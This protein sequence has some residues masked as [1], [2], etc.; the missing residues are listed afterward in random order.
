M[1]A[2]VAI[3]VAL[4]VLL[5]TPL[6]AAADDD[7]VKPTVDADVD[8]VSFGATLNE[9]HVFPYVAVRGKINSGYYYVC[10]MRSA[11]DIDQ[12]SSDTPRQDFYA[13]E[14]R[15]HN[16]KPNASYYEVTPENKQTS[17]YIPAAGTLKGT[18]RIEWSL[19]RHDYYFKGY[20]DAGGDMWLTKCLATKHKPA[21]YSWSATRKYPEGPHEG[22]ESVSD[23]DCT[24]WTDPPTDEVRTE[25]P[26][27]PT[28]ETE[29]VSG[30]TGGRGSEPDEGPL[31]QS[32]GVGAFI[33][34]TVAVVGLLLARRR[35]P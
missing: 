13:Y 3:L 23:L 34:L 19:E 7:P 5:L 2:Q 31:G 29:P 27:T 22:C 12:G 24:I 9:T 10:Q 8:I 26:P 1:Q 33:V 17:R 16:S 6:P 20:R 35:F 32:P 28:D 25:A 4:S 30:D 21:E 18:T 11:V 14:G 15:W